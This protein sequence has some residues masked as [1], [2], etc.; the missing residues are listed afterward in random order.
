MFFVLLVIKNFFINL[1]KHIYIFFYN[2]NYFLKFSFQ[3]QFFFSPKNIKNC[4]P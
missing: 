2:K 1:T 3:T 4:F